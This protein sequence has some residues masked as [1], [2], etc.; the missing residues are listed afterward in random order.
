[1]YNVY[2][3][4]VTVFCVYH[5][6][7]K[8]SHFSIA[9]CECVTNKLSVVFLFFLLLSFDSNQI[10]SNNKS[11]TRTRERVVYVTCHSMYDNAIC[12]M[13]YAVCH[14][15]NRIA[16]QISGMDWNRR[17]EC[18]KISKWEQFYDI[19]LFDFF[20]FLCV[21]PWNHFISFHIISHS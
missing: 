20:F 11:L 17:I 9:V 19:E 3:V 7:W 12:Y 13:L 8:G 6:P 4:C 1:M 14:S 16:Q 2:I 15:F 21:Y 5:V 18:Q 10:N